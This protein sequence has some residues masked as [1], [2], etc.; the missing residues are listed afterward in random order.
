MIFLQ[1]PFN[2]MSKGKDPLIASTHAPQK[3]TCWLSPLDRRFLSCTPEKNSRTSV[4][5]F[6]AVQVYTAV[7]L[8]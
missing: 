1:R 3:T 2:K 5:E 8:K 6:D 4:V 7:I